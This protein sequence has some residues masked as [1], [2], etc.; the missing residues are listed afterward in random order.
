M[1][2]VPMTTS[3]TTADTVQ[4][5]VFAPVP[6]YAMCTEGVDTAPG[7]HGP[8]Q[9]NNWLPFAKVMVDWLARVKTSVFSVTGTSGSVGV[10]SLHATANETTDRAQAAIRWNAF[11][12]PLI[13]EW[14]HVLIAFAQLPRIEDHGKRATT[15]YTTVALESHS[16]AKLCETTRSGGAPVLRRKTERRRRYVPGCIT[17][18]LSW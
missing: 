1:S 7:S 6:K 12:M 4:P 10:L 14:S 17:A 8:H 16:T 5:G 13:Q 11:T 15:F 18:M 3:A 9:A 2:G